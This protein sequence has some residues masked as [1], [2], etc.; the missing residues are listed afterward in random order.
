M[1]E[2]KDYLPWRARFI[3]ACAVP[4]DAPFALF[5]ALAALDEKIPGQEKFVPWR[6]WA[7]QKNAELL[8]AIERNGAGPETAW[9]AVELCQTHLGEARSAQ[10]MASRAVASIVEKLNERAAAFPSSLAP[11]GYQTDPELYRKRV[12]G[13]GFLSSKAEKAAKAACAQA[14]AEG[15]DLPEAL[16]ELQKAKR[17]L[18]GFESCEFAAERSLQLAQGAFDRAMALAEELRELAPYLDPAA[19]DFS[20]R[21]G[22]SWLAEALCAAAGAAADPENSRIYLSLAQELSALAA[23]AESASAGAAPA[24]D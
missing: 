2:E 21:A 10:A 12:Q 1:I 13:V 22:P 4:A 3:E 18:L 8:M 15:L 11:E 19:M 16:A 23:A 24:Q 17:L 9:R 7:L 14:Q 20:L 5:A 6:A